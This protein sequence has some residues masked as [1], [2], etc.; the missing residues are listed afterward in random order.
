MV[1]ESLAA[2]ESRLD[3]SR[4]ARIHRSAIVALDRVSELQIDDRGCC[5]VVLRN[6]TTLPL[7]RRQRDTLEARLR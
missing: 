7:S 3:P 4:F 2:L 5:R 1:R 6:G